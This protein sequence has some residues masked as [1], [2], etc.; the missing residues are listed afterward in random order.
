MRLDDGSIPLLIPGPGAYE[1]RGA[2]CSG[3]RSGRSES[4]MYRLLTPPG[5]RSS[6]LGEP[7][8]GW[9]KPEPTPAS[10]VFAANLARGQNTENPLRTRIG[11][12]QLSKS[13]LG[14]LT[15]LKI[16]TDDAPMLVE[17][18][19]ATHSHSGPS[20]RIDNHQG[21]DRSP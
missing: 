19:L 10:Q 21:S 18:E 13:L 15:R 3:S 8:S 12:D 5:P 16:T 14:C 2:P 4:P 20:I 1:T 11:F 6:L 7:G 9:R 17:A